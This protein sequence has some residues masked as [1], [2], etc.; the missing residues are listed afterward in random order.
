MNNK[1]L[2][3]NREL[4]M[5]VMAVVGAAVTRVGIWLLSWY[6]AYLVFSW[7]GVV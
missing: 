7:T 6:A 1:W 2:N 4:T 5:G 3:K